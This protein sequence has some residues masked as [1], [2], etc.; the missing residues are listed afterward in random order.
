M[1]EKQI[2][3]DV[4]ADIVCPWCFLGR[5]RLEKAITLL[6]EFDINVH[7]KPFQLSPEIPQQ[8]KPYQEHMRAI[9]GNR[10]AVDE[11]ERT[12][13]ALGEE[14]GIAFDFSAIARM[15]N[16]LD[17]HRVIYWAAQ[18]EN[19]V[20]DALVGELFSRFF[21][22]GQD[23]GKAEILVEAAAAAGMK[24]RVVEKLLTTDIDRDTIQQDITGA[25]YIGVR[26]VPCFI[27]DKKFVVMGAQPIELLADAIQQ[28]AD[29]FEPGTVEDR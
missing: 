13:I 11:A 20:Q 3:I 25:H 28:T 24:A 17:A 7:W 15:P 4:I 22:Q 9:L 16:T 12:L 1:N 14:D 27:V 8:G 23:I 5:K 29:G 6:P 18:D 19:G 21:E 2:M 26:G 10:D